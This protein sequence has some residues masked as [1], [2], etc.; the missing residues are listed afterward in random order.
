M[1]DA[2]RELF[3][4]LRDLEG[5]IQSGGYVLLHAIVFAETGLL[6]GFFLPGDSLLFTAGFLASTGFL[7]VWVLL[8]G[9]SLAAIAGDQVGYL[10]GRKAGDALYR[11]ED[12]RFFKRK[13]LERAHAFYEKYG[14]KTIVLARFVPIVR[15][16]APTVAG[17]ARMEYRRF[18]FYNV[19]G[20]VFWVFSMVGAGFLLGRAFPGLRKHLEV[21]VLG[22]VF[23]SVL[24][25]VFEA[26]K[27][28]RERKATADVTGEAGE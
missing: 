22:I 20:G 26:W 5:L 24:P 28:R 21:V 16:F 8:V 2:L 7:N 23:L 3:H 9:L 6:V 11:R 17:A 14:G 15:T 13:H 10:I 12:S 4:R 25:I 18:V 19:A 1:I 27:A